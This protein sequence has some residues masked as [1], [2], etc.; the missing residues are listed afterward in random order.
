MVFELIRTVYATIQPNHHIRRS[1]SV[2]ARCLEELADFL[3]VVAGR[4][5]KEYPTGLRVALHKRSQ[6]NPRAV[7][8]LP[9]LNLFLPQLFP[10]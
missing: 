6:S 5:V 4:E 9:R 2:T 10:Y 3:I 1:R 7:P 8:S